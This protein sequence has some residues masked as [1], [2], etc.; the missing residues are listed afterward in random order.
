MNT[1]YRYFL[2]DALNNL[3]SY[4]LMSYFFWIQ[5]LIISQWI[6]IW[7]FQ[8]SWWKPYDCWSNI[9]IIEGYISHST[10]SRQ[11]RLV[12]GFIFALEQGGP[13]WLGMGIR[14]KLCGTWNPHKC[15]QTNETN[16]DWG[17]WRCVLL[18]FHFLDFR[19]TVIGWCKHS[20]STCSAGCFE[21]A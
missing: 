7:L 15:A 5:C 2:I 9:T 19:F 6:T 3:N 21:M 17:Q 14:A 12:R 4:L 13:W 8:F 11:G 1:L 10:R 18:G 20:N 16:K